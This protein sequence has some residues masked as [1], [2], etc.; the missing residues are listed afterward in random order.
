MAHSAALCA[1]K[2]SEACAGVPHVKGRGWYGLRRVAAD[3]AEEIT[4]DARVK[5]CLG[6]W[7]HG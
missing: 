3:L 7:R 5:D 6:G 2:K 4:T 1:F